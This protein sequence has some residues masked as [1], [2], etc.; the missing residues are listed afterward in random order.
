[1]DRRAWMMLL[2]LAAI[3]GASYAFIK[4][5]VRDLS[6]AMIAWVRVALAA[7]VLVP[8]AASRSSLGIPPGSVPVLIALAA[9]QVAI[10]FVL[11]GVGEEEVTSSMAGILVASTPLFVA[12]LA[13]RLDP[14]ERSVG[15]GMWGV[16]AGFAGVSLLL[17]VD[18]GGSQAE[19]LGGIAIVVAGLCYAVGG[20]INKR[21]FTGSDPIGVA[22][23]V[24]VVSTGL[25]AP[26]ALLA[27]P[28]EVPG[29]GPVAAVAA[30]GVAGTGIAFAIFFSLIAAVGPARTMLVT[31]LVP[32]FAVAY[33]VAF[34]NE[35][36]SVAT[37][38]GL[39]LIVGGSY[40]AA[41]SGGDSVAI[42]PE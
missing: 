9:I 6:P 5:G 3:W 8:I 36:V 32:A 38:A 30:L 15:A 22:A 14:E 29:L 18:L 39:A 35:A 37:V 11:I 28:D 40:L 13:P 2:L 24:M 1:M 34:L 23:W 12:L 26:F 20:F 7:A 25:L 19:L 10:P 16:L 31:Y 42:A 4:I 17:G 41:Q 27:M 33:G 21:G